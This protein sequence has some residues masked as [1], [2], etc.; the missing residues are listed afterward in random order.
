M[1]LHVRTGPLARR[2]WI[3]SPSYCTAIQKLRRPSLRKRTLDT[4]KA[5]THTKNA[6]SNIVPKMDASSS[7]QPDDK[8]NT[9]IDA[10]STIAAK[11]EAPQSSQVDDK[12]DPVIKKAKATIT[13][14]MVNPASV[15]FVE[16]KR[17]DRKIRSASLSTPFAATSGG[18]TRQA[19]KP[20]TGRFYI[21]SKKTGRTSAVPLWLRSRTAISAIENGAPPLL[22]V[23]YW[24]LTDNPTAPAFHGS[25]RTNFAQ[26][27]NPTNAPTR[28]KLT[29]S[30]S[31]ASAMAMFIVAS[32]PT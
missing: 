12:S 6:K 3:Q 1:G 31:N 19:E 4:R 18:K 13:A 24:H 27:T 10:K 16:M 5:N 11:T 20:E 15:E 21:S 14:M 8:S 17:T 2:R 22:N 7:V 26:R 9:V 29:A 25:F 30:I 28:K 23:R 32:Y